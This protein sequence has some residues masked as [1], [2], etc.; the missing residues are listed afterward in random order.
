VS[1]GMS[2]MLTVTARNLPPREYVSTN[3]IPR[4]VAAGFVEGDESVEC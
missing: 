2:V 4:V 1:A 3:T